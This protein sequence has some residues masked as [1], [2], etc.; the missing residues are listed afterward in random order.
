MKDK[1]W[2]G[3]DNDRQRKMKNLLDK[4]IGIGFPKNVDIKRFIEDNLQSMWMFT[5]VQRY[6]GQFLIKYV[7]E[8]SSMHFS[9]INYRSSVIQISYEAQVNT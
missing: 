3:G 4:L 8:C 5:K 6:D 1:D 2:T 9:M 7:L